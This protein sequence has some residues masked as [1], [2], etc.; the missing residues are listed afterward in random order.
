VDV[1]GLLFLEEEEELEKPKIAG[2]KSILKVSVVTVMNGE[3]TLG[4]TYRCFH[5]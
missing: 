2:M 4:R 5:K 3:T 1:F